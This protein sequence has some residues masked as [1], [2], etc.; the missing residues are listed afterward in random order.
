M[1]GVT[2]GAGAIIAAHAVVTKDV[3]PY[4]IVGGNPAKH[5][6]FRFSQDII[7]LLLE[8]RWWELPFDDI[9]NIVPVL[10]NTPDVV[11]LQKLV[12]QYR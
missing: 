7:N 1:S 6:R 5:I 4:E 2:I 11:E 9:Q 8:L 12:K 3:A 10:C